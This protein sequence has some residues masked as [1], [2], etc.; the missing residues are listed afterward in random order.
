[1]NG[2]QQNNRT[3]TSV[4]PHLF[5]A[6]EKISFTIVYL[7]L[8]LVAI[9]GNSFVIH[10]AR[11]M[12][13]AGRGPF[14][15]LVIS[16]AASDILYGVAV[17][18]DN[19]KYLYVQKVWFP[20][21]FGTF[22]CKFSYFSF[23]FAIGS[24]IFAL[25]AMTIDRYL[26]IVPRVKKPLT[27][28]SVIKVLVA[29]FGIMFVLLLII[30]FTR[31]TVSTSINNV[32]RTY[33]MEFY[34]KDEAV[35]DKLKKA[36]HVSCFVLFYVFPV[37]T[38]SVLYFFIIRFLWLRK[39]PGNRTEQ[40][41][42]QRRKQLKRVT[43]MLVT[44]ATTFAITWLPIHVLHYYTA[45]DNEWRLPP[46]L[47]LLFS[48]SGHSN[49]ATNPCF[50]VVFNKEYRDELKRLW[51]RKQTANVSNENV[52]LGGNNHALELQEIHN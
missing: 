15:I 41:E 35:A 11:K 39:I 43:L 29:I 47:P 33:C 14:N 34:S 13:A 24:S 38:M 1:M 2:S 19:I 31:T 46:F 49:C 37:I 27:R 48:L 10:V 51:S 18:I 5:S 21:G 50:Y 30:S 4:F 3:I 6:A 44:M 25:T 28:R 26:A 40:N 45:F 9:L 36:E 8:F 12:L 16:M 52:V 7:I 42:T 17:A 23:V 20:G 32:T 22:L